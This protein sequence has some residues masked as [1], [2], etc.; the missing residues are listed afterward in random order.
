MTDETAK[1]LAAVYVKQMTEQQ[2]A[3]AIY[4]HAR[5]FGCRFEADR[6]RHFCGMKFGTETEGEPK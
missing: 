4:D 2:I 3:L 6:W 5:I 1:K